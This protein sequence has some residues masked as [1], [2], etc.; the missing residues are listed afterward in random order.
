MASLLI[1]DDEHALRET[2]CALLSNAGYSVVGVSDGQAGLDHCQWAAV[3]LVVT[4][5]LMPGQDG[6]Q[7]IRALRTLAP[8]PKIIALTGSLAFERQD[9]LAFARES[10]ADRALG[11][12]VRKDV[13]LETVRELLRESAA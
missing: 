3:D 9:M 7:T 12:P 4:D 5:L 1:I 11:K 13:L 2:L 8:V 6:F 10:G